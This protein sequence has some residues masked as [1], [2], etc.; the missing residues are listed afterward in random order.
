MNPGE[1]G[2]LEL[3]L[4]EVLN[5]VVEHGYCGNASG[6][7]Q[8]CLKR[9]ADAVHC[10]IEDTGRPLPN[11][12]LPI[13]QPGQVPKS[14]MEIAEGGRGWALIRCL[15]MDLSYTRE[16]GRNCLRFRIP[17]QPSES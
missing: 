17:L 7:V 13:V 3:A 12:T 10:Q 16:N 6:E 8:I 4:A 14:I 11:L 9:S 15:T 1:A 5:N 2:A